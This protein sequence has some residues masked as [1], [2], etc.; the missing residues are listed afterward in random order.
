MGDVFNPTD[1]HLSV[2]EMVR[3]FAE[4]E[5]APQAEE[6]DRDE[7]FNHSLFR[8][9]GEQGLLGLTADERFGGAELDAT[10]AVIVHEELAAADPG[11]CLSYLAH[12]IL[13]VHNLHING[14]ED[15]KAR[16]LPQACSGEHIGGMCMS[17]PGAGTDVLGMRT[18]AIRDGD[19]YV[20][21]G[22]KMWITNGSVTDSDLGDA[23]LVYAHT[24]ERRRDVTLFIV[25]KSMEG[26]S[27]GQKI[28]D[29]LGMRASSTSIITSICGMISLISL[30]AL[31]I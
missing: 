18:R 5:V 27:L 1:E 26:F 17:E 20:I 8:Q 29:K 7:R 22:S 3:S 30:R 10:A 15:Q 11:F 31:F 21:D 25:D 4:S 13:Y 12:S 6:H 28:K 9:L 14:S 23:F 19:D 24:S 2:R 16:Y